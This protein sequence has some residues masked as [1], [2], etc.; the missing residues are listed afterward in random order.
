MRSATLRHGRLHPGHLVAG[1]LCATNKRRNY[2][3]PGLLCTRGEKFFSK[4]FFQK[5]VS[6]NFQKKFLFQK[7]FFSK[8]VPKKFQKEVQKIFLFHITVFFC[9]EFFYN[10]SSKTFHASAIVSIYHAHSIPFNKNKKINGR[11]IKKS[12][13]NTAQCCRQR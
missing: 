3:A 7:K 11:R 6:F 9:K 13:L 10:F 8:Q 5:Q 12:S 2:Y 1:R 4:L